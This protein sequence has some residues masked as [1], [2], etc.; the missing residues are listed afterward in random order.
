MTGRA[1]LGIRIG[2]ARC[3]N[4]PIDKWEQRDHLAFSALFADARPDPKGGMRTGILFDPD[5]GKAVQPRTLP[6]TP[7]TNGIA[8]TRGHARTVADFVLAGDH[9]MF[10]RNMANRTFAALMGKGLVEP[11]DDH[12]LSNPAVHES[13]LAHLSTL[14]ADGDLRKLV[15]HIVTSRM[16]QTDP[17][18]TEAAADE[19]AV[20]FFARR[21]ARA[22][23]PDTFATAVSRAL[24][25]RP[26]GRLTRSPLA[27]QL[28]LL[29]SAFLNEAVRES[30]SLET[31]AQ[32]AP[33]AKARL[34]D[35]FVLLLSREPRRVEVDAF[36]SDVSKDGDRDGVADLAFALLA[37]REFGSIR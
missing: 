3:H 14:A 6:V 12:R 20:R 22:M 2:C 34:R 15:L 5:T 4:S 26:T 16:Y 9:G 30:G 13:M 21:V 27:R 31:I 19:A 23:P 17:Q 28:A 37:S 1:F 10:A 36:L 35:L 29:N 25:T 18:P 8:K 11:L 32:F 7:A 33:D 24:G